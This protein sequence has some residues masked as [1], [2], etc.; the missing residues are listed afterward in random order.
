MHG[1]A[2][3]RRRHRQLRRV[4][5]L[6]VAASDLDEFRALGGCA[7]PQL[8]EEQ[9]EVDVE[10]LPLLGRDLVRAKQRKFLDVD[11]MLFLRELRQSAPT[12]RAE[13]VEIARRYLEPL[14]PAELPADR[15]S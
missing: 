1:H 13:L 5:R 9:H 6:E 3:S 11:F 2:D 12:E 14:D 7:L 4:Q 15:K 10:E 8:A